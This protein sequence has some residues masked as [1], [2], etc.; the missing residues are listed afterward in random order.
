MDLVKA[1]HTNQPVDG[2][3]RT[4]LRPALDGILSASDRFCGPR[5]PRAAIQARRTAIPEE[6]S[7]RGRCLD[8]G[9]FHASDLSPSGLVVGFLEQCTLTLEEHGVANGLA[10]GQQGLTLIGG[11]SRRVYRHRKPLCMQ[12]VAPPMVVP[13]RNRCSA[14]GGGEAL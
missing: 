9:Q 4:P 8:S 13:G 11:G 2:I 12:S 5:L 1:E 10:V 6:S 14:L 3:R 7:R